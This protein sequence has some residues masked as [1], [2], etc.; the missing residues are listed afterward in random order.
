M[1]KLSVT[2]VIEDPV[3]DGPSDKLRGSGGAE[4][5]L[6][7]TCASAA[8]KKSKYSLSS[9]FESSVPPFIEG[10]V[11]DGPSDKLRGS[12]GAEPE[13]D[14]ACASA[15]LKKSKY[16]ISFGNSSPRFSN[17]FT[18]SFGTCTVSTYA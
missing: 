7:G 4:L 2:P 14:G 8:L 18:T 15:A 12:G 5:E 10:P 11:D 6:D 17:T 1:F 9:L 16:F 3:D 13:L